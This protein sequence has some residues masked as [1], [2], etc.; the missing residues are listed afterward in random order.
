[1]SG[2]TTLRAGL[3]V[4]AAVLVVVGTVGVVPTAGEQPA[5]QETAIQPDDPPDAVRDDTFGRSGDDELEA[6]VAADDGYALVGRTETADGGS[7]GWL[8][9]VN[10]SGDRRFSTTFGGPDEDRIFDAVK[11]EDGYLLVGWRT[12]DR[13]R[14]GWLLKVDDR[15]VEQ[16][17]KTL[18][19]PQWDGFHA[20]T[21]T[22]DGNY[23]AAGRFH[24]EGWA[25]KFDA[26]G[27]VQW[28]RTYAGTGNG[29]R[30]GS[31]AAT[32]DGFLFA[33][34]NDRGNG[35]LTGLA[36]RANESGDEQWNRSYGDGTRIW[37]A[38]TTDDGFLLAGETNL[39]ADQPRAWAALAGDDGS[40][41]TRWTDEI[42]GS[43]FMDAVPVDDGFLLV[44][45]ANRHDSGYD[46]V[47]ARFDDDLDRQWGAIAG[48]S[49]WDI[50]FSGIATDDG[51][52]LC[53]AT[54]SSGA[55]GLDGWLVKL[56]NGEESGS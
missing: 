53:G 31:V 3:V 34:W 22:P 2:R 50:A 52:F 9:R 25:V 51:Y 14:Q 10:D 4:S 46:A 13:G 29:S 7:D 5:V 23:V 44:G 42:P 38:G 17:S 35:S 54:S 56:E 32:D 24:F 28:N 55:G 20:I 36:V 43:R 12:T 47:A 19:G 6:A 21:E 41:E 45:G 16:W 30:F 39:S 48:G 37:T 27:E 40:V 11:T 26:D 8:I 18:G 33:G 1:M 15:G 49:Q